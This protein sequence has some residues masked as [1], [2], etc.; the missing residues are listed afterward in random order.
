MDMAA[1]G[2][3]DYFW[4]DESLKGAICSL[5]PLSPLSPHSHLAVP[6]LSVS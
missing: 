4:E 5:P 6:Q 3:A 1:S 2:G